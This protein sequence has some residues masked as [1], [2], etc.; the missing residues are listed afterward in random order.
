MN[1]NDTLGHEGYDTPQE[2]Q[3]AIQTAKTF[4]DDCINEIGIDPEELKF[5]DSKQVAEDIESFRQVI[6]DDKFMLYGDSYGTEIAQIYARAHA[7]H[8]SGLILDGTIDT[9]LSRDQL[10]LSQIDAF[11]K[12]LLEVF[13]ACDA[14]PDCSAGMSD[15]SQAAYDELAQKLADAPIPYTFPLSNGDKAQRLFTYNMLDYTTAYQLYGLEDRWDLMRAVAA[16][17][18]GDMLPLVRLYY[19]N[20]NIDPGTGSYLGDPSFSDTMFYIVWCGD[21][22]YYRGTS[23]ERTASILE[24]GEK[25]SGIATRLDVGFVPFALFCAF[26][27][28]SPTEPE[29]LTPLKAEGVPTIVLNATLDPATPFQGGK[30]V[31]EHHDNGYHIYVNGGVHVVYLSGYSCPNRYVDDFLVNGILPE[32][33]EIVCDWGNAVISP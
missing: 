10:D 27:P 30:A 16:A 26:L 29:Q 4:V 28:D 2:Q 8:L 31:F 23:E 1:F 32:Q 18:E 17:D 9:T 20:A 5:F 13:K 12:V 7:D 21:G 24:E 6:G 15:G 14:S 25:Q 22:A 19:D 3:D 33:R 11:N